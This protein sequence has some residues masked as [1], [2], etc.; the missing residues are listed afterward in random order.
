MTIKNIG[1]LLAAIILVLYCAQAS[2]QD[3][4]SRPVT[5]VVPWPAGGTTDISMRALATATEKHLKQPIVIENRPG[6]G[7]VL[8][9][10]TVAEKAAPDGYTIT[11]IAITVFRWPFMRKTTLDPAKD[12]TYI[13][14]LTG[15]TFGVVVRADA[16]WKTF[17]E[18]L[19]YAKAH[20]GTINYGTPGAGTS[21]HITME[22]IAKK[23]GIKWTHVPFKGTSETTGALLGGHIHAV[24]DATGWGPQ[25]QAGTFRLLVIW[26]AA[27]SKNYPDAPTL[28]ESGI[29]LVS[30]SPFGLAGPKGMDAK[31]VKVLHDAFKK[32]SEEPA[33][34]AEMMK[35]DQEPAYLSS[36]DYKKYA[37]QQLVEQK[38]LIEAIGLKQE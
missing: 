15:Y 34:I 18:F 28:K 7:G 38:A 10:Q 21:L 6:A 17:R 3:F 19:D 37:D 9:A 30:N 24:A 27:R 4:P 25:V 16:P 35:F 31:V 26:N 1:G 36:A 22:Q 20:P 23:E 14:G 29:D 11:Q 8:G 12:F 2:A 13:I 33:Y 32:G 5:L